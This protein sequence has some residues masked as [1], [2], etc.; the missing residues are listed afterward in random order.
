MDRQARLRQ[1][2]WRSRRGVLEL[3]MLLRPFALEDLPA[4]DDADLQ[5]YDRLL[6][7]EDPEL[8]LWLQQGDDSGLHPDLLPLVRR[9]RSRNRLDPVRS[10]V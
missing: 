3:D 9:I 4:L 7:C 10:S 5:C 8:L 1:L 2:Q 6:D